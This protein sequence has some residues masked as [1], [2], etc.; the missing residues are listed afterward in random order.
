MDIEA[1]T[2]ADLVKFT[3]AKRRTVQL[4]AEAGAIRA[5]R[6]TERAG[7]GT[8]RRFSR[9][10]A[11]IACILHGFALKKLSIGMLINIGAALRDQ[12]GTD[13]N[14]EAVE[15]VMLND[16]PMYLI[17]TYIDPNKSLS[18]FLEPATSKKAYLKQIE[19]TLEAH[20][21][22]LDLPESMTFIIKFNTYLNQPA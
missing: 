13:E 12:L 14:L 5:D 10:E 3:G 9:T 1:Y 8:H 2:L 17:F 7:T 18:T 22:Y 19:L 11:I 20:N 6:E 15:R 21:E 4:W 16:N